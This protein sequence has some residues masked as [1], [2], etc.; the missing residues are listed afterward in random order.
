MSIFLYNSMQKNNYFISYRIQKVTDVESLLKSLK[1]SF[2]THEIV[3]NG[4]IIK[5][6]TPLKENDIITICPILV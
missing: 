5:E 1:V 3:K 6:D 4:R 2:D